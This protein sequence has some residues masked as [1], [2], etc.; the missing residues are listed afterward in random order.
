MRE[1]FAPAVAGLVAT[2][3]VLSGCSS[4]TPDPEEAPPAVAQT[5]PK[6]SPEPEL[7][8][9]AIAEWVKDQPWYFSANGVEEA[10]TINVADGFASDD[11]MRTYE[12][13]SFVESDANGDG[14]PDIAVSITEL[15][16]NGMLELWYVWLGVEGATG[17]DPLAE[18]MLF[19]IA[20]TSR[21][22]DVVHEVAATDGGFR[23]TE[24]LRHPLD[25]GDCSETG[26]WHQTRDVTVS[27][28]E[29]TAYPILTSPLTAWG[30]ICPV[31]T[32]EWLDGEPVTGTVARSAPPA[33]APPATREDETWAVF[34]LP[35]TPLLAAEGVSFFGFMPE[36]YLEHSDEDVAA[37]PV[38]THCAVTDLPEES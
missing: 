20:R 31:P 24:S 14:I 17:D 35:E 19:P 37:I 16:G 18:Q 23:V 15:D 21:C 7:T 36:S 22:G 13:G 38:R 1:V 6:P 27:G 8:G 34:G 32:L 5:A 2:L 12:V 25:P 33:D 29:G 3:L 11:F 10:V 4:N 30:G 9:E 26:T 28:F